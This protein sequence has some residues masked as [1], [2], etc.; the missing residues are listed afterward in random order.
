MPARRHADLLVPLLS[1]VVGTLFFW[2]NDADL[3]WTAPYCAGGEWP[4]G[5]EGFWAALYYFGTLPALIAVAAAMLVLV[6]GFRKAGAA[7]HR[8]RAVY[9]IL[10]MGIGP[11][12]LTN[13]ILKD[14][15]GR[16]RPREVIELG[17]SER[18]EQILRIDPSS[19]GKSF[20]CGHATM[21]F[22][23]IGGFYIF[24]RRN[25]ALAFG[26]LAFGIVSG[27]L[28][29]WAR[30]VQGG[31]FPSDV[32]WAGGLIWLVAGLLARAVKPEEL[33]PVDPGFKPASWLRIAA[34][35]LML[36]A[37]I[38]G[39]LLATPVSG[40]AEYESRDATEILLRLE[41]SN[42]TV[43]SGVPT[44]VELRSR[45]F[46]LPG[47]A[48]R[49]TWTGEPGAGGGRVAKLFQRRSG[50][51]TEL[52]QEVVVQIDPVRI[53]R[54]KIEMPGG[55]IALTP[56]ASARPDGAR[57]WEIA[58]GSGRVLVNHAGAIIDAEIDGQKVLDQEPETDRI[59]IRSADGGVEFAPPLPGIRQ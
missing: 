18:F 54:V 51:A 2:L 56:P 41:A 52:S 5:E 22:F 25:R 26:M 21:G 47:T 6:A 36:P 19:P 33:P 48:I 15:S 37:L 39:A 40:R 11:G 50:L 9:L 8:R 28:I 59:R 23:F 42:I 34:A 38:F 14:N 32:L 13:A 30:V 53:A 3:A 1:L 49:S 24:R 17:G 43:A 35:A 16:P 29:G 46:G 10:L 12:L 57:R 27:G 7:R 20:P 58:A 45:G 44:R 31:H 4:F 55:R